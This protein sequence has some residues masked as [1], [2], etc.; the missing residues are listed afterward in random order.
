[1][2]IKRKHNIAKIILKI[3]TQKKTLSTNLRD[4]HG[5]QC[6]H[7]RIRKDCIEKFCKDL[8]ELGMEMINLKKKEMI[9][10]THIEIKFYEKQKVY[11]TCEKKFR[12]DKNPKRKYDLYHKVIDHCHYTGKFRGVGHNICNLGYNIPKKVPVVFHNGSTYDYLFVIKKF[13]KECRD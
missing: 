6:A 8:K 11:Y 1:M 2:F 9:P 10:L 12:D 3:L 13:E 7:L 4:T 5:V